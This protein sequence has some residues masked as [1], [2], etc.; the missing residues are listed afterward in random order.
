MKPDLQKSGQWT[1]DKFI[2]YPEFSNYRTEAFLETPPVPV[3][4]PKSRTW[5]Y[6]LAA[7]LIGLAALW[8]VARQVASARAKT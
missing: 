1:E 2:P 4:L 7:A 3:D 8:L 6:A 5:Q